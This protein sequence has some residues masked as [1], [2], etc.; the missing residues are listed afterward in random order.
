MA[1]K[2]AGSVARAW[3]RHVQDC[4]RVPQGAYP[5]LAVTPSSS[6][7]CAVE[8]PIPLVCARMSCIRLGAVSSITAGRSA[9]GPPAT[10]ARA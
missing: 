1:V 10:G 3:G 6:L 4:A 2:F 8:R 7:E 5:K 9:L